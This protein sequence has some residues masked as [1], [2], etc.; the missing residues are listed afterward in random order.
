MN[1]I[2]FVRKNRVYKIDNNRGTT[3][4]I[5]GDRVPLIRKE[6]GRTRWIFWEENNSGYSVYAG[7][8]T[9]I[10]ELRGNNR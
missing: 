9:T 4:Y 1:R 8:F 3:K 7:N 6:K 10:N 2:G 5:R